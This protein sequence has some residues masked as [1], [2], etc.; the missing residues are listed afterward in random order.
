MTT[1]GH[2]FSNFRDRQLCVQPFYALPE[3][4]DTGNVCHS[5][6]T[7]AGER[8]V[9]RTDVNP[10]PFYGYTC[11]HSLHIRTSAPGKIKCKRFQGLYSLVTL[12]WR[13]NGRDSVSNHQPHDCLLNP[14]YRRRSKKTSKLRVTGLCVGNSPGTGEFPAQMASNAANCSIWWRHHETLSH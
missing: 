12:Q 3:R 4:T 2:I 14:L 1:S 8:R 7:H 9:W 10:G 13:Q 6:G 11:C 5:L